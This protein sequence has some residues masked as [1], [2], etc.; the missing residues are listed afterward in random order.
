MSWFRKMMLAGML[1]LAV[2]LPLGAATE[3]EAAWH[4][5]AHVIHHHEF[6]VFYR[7]NCYGPWVRYGCFATRFR[8]EHVA[9][10]LQHDGFEV[11]IQ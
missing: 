4:P 8:A 5:V 7:A 3:A 2:L 11:M 1:S 6:S 10:H 9:H